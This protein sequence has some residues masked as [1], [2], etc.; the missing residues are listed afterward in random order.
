M[1][2]NLKS[3]FPEVVTNV[4]AMLG[5]TDTVAVLFSSVSVNVLGIVGSE[6]AKVYSFSGIYGIITPM[7]TIPKTTKETVVR[8]RLVRLGLI[9]NVLFT[10]LKNI[11][12]SYILIYERKTFKH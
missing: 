7:E 1:I 9:L 11:T 6:S 12:F 5:L 3:S 4:P 10:F 8:K 2:L